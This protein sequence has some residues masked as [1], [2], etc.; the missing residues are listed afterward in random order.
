VRLH[1][2]PMPLVGE[3]VP[4]AVSPSSVL[5]IRLDVIITLCHG[6]DRNQ[7]SIPRHELT[8][9]AYAEGSFVMVILSMFPYCQIPCSWVFVENSAGAQMMVGDLHLIPGKRAIDLH[10][11]TLTQMQI[12]GQKRIFRWRSPLRLLWTTRRWRK[13]IGQSFALL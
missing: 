7:I 12:D 8:W 1:P 6:L 13:S 3:C 10:I 11:W 5:I 2:Q 9:V 4:S